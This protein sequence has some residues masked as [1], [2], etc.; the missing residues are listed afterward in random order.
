[1]GRRFESFCVRHQ[2][3]GF[4]LD[5]FLDRISQG[6]RLGVLRLDV[7]VWGLS[8]LLQGYQYVV[9]V[10]EEFLKLGLGFRV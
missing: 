3:V 8:G 1:M 5:R 2:A 9:G 10:T 4:T 6:W 7:G